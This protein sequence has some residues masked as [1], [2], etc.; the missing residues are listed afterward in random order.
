MST[1]QRRGGDG[2]AGGTEREA[3]PE[4]V[5]RACVPEN[6]RIVLQRMGAELLANEKARE[7]FLGI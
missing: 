6:D 7:V 3:D 4:S 1:D 5:Q 2:V